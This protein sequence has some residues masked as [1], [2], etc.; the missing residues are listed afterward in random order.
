MA[1]GLLRSL[2]PLLGIVSDPV[3]TWRVLS[4]LRSA[5]RAM[6]TLSGVRVTE[7]KQVLPP[8]LCD[9]MPILRTVLSLSWEV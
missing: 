6:Q 3:L 2:A 8:I 4:I 9:W 5:L 1:P 7:I